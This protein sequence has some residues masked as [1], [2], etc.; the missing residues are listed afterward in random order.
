MLALLLAPLLLLSTASGSGA[1]GIDET[2]IRLRDKSRGTEILEIFSRPFVSKSFGKS[3]ALVVGIGNYDHHDDL[4]APDKDAVRVQNFLRY[5]AG[6]DHIV[7]LTDDKASRARIEGLMEREFPKLIQENDRFLFYFSGH[8]E[9]RDLR[10]DDKRGYLVLKSASS[11]EWDVMIDMP[12][13]QQWIENLGHARHTLFLLDA[14]FSG[15]AGIESKGGDNRGQTINRLIQPGHH[16][17]TAGVEGE[18]AYIFNEASLFTSAFLAAVREGDYTNDGIISLGEI[19]EYINSY[20]DAKRAQLGGNIKMSPHRSDAR[21]EDNVG[22]FFFLSKGHSENVSDTSLVETEV[23]EKGRSAKGFGFITQEGG[24]EDLLVLDP[25]FRAIAE[26]QRVEFDITKG[27]KGL[28]A[29][30]VRP[31]P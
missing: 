16:L 7:T 28:K 12:R 2:Y 26:K 4:S 6:F 8:G 24:G 21:F 13:V 15:L 1:T 25:D 27:P 9:T 18:K 31:V 29:S 22:E 14:C 3:Y 5:E 10:R 17:L 11:D 30:N 20:L 19:F 23:K